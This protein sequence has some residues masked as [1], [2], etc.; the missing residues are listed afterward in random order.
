MERFFSD[1]VKPDPENRLTVC[2]RCG[3]TVTGFVSATFDF[4]E[5][6]TSS[7]DHDTA[8]AREFRQEQ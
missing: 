3:P 1:W 7:E 5:D 2:K 6:F 8:N 4:A